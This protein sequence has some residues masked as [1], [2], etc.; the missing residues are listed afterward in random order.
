MILLGSA[1]AS[2]ISMSHVAACFAR[3]ADGNNLPEQ[4]ETRQTFK[5]TPGTHVE[6]SRIK[7]SVDIETADIDT[8][9][10]YIVSSAES[11]QV[12]EQYKIVIE[13]S[14]QSL[15]ISG[16]PQEG[17][18]R[19]G[20]GPDVR[21]QVR[22]RLPRRIE[23]AIQSISGEV[24]IG[25]VGGQL[26]A[27]SVGGVLTVGTVSGQVQINSVS[28]GVRLGDVG[29]QLIANSIGG[30]LSVGAVNGQVQ[31]NGVSG[32]VAIGRV[33]RQVELKSVSGGVKIEQA[34]GSLDVTG[35]SGALSVGISK[36][37]MGGVQIRNVSGEVELRFSDELN[38]Q[39]NTDNISGKVS[40]D[41][42]RVNV[43]SRE[44]ETAIRA[45]IG[46]GGPTISIIGV[47]NSVRLA[48]GS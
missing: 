37:G 42:P 27:N 12:L 35:V 3:H 9:E 44:R 29:G 7:G 41:V 6:V 22:L 23:L 39:L 26:I 17:N 28:G 13:H 2:I 8:A 10:I 1:M 20:F 4:Q 5:L 48:Q 21:H 46:K 32:G 19:S 43:Q 24:R 25:D 31:V 34:V 36:L 11:R 15:I 18:S 38:A 33:N 14:S 16:A 47:S 40:L 30:V 45:V